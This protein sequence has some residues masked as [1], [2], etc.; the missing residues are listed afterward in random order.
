MR[1]QL[2]GR[3][4]ETD[5]GTLAELLQEQQIDPRSVAAALNG[6]F[7]PRSRYASQQLE[8]GNQLEILSPMQGG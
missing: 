7:V 6:E 1:V 4:I 8:A 3:T 2:N 5:A